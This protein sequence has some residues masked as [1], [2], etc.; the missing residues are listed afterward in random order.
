MI[1]LVRSVAKTIL[2]PACG[3]PALSNHNPYG[4]S[5]MNL[6]NKY[7]PPEDL[8]DKYGPTYPCDDDIYMAIQNEAMAKLLESDVEPSSVELALYVIG[9]LGLDPRDLEPV[10]ELVAL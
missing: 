4:G 3:D 10:E 7:N 1:R 6:R 9:R 2:A 5:R 8:H